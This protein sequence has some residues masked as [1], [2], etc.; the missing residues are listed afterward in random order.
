MQLNDGFE[1][2]DKTAFL[3]PCCLCKPVNQFQGISPASPCHMDLEENSKCQAAK[4]QGQPQKRVKISPL[5]SLSLMSAHSCAFL[6]CPAVPWAVPD[7]WGKTHRQGGPR[8]AEQPKEPQTGCDNCCLR[9]SLLIS[10]G[11]GQ[12]LYLPS[13]GWEG[14]SKLVHM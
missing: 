10:L 7:P 12:G 8:T 2:D 13:W 11:C 9:G 1:A 5:F 3:F 14:G 6:L 4:G